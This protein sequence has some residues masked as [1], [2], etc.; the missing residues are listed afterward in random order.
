MGSNIKVWARGVG[1]APA[2]CLEL[3]PGTSNGA[4]SRAFS[5]ES[6]GLGLQIPTDLRPLLKAARANTLGT[7]GMA[8]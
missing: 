4:A 7:D 2:R 5:S 6:L 3:D 8:G 1:G